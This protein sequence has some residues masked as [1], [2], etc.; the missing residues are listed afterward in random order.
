MAST[1][2]ARAARIDRASRPAAEQRPRLTVLARPEPDRSP[3]PFV[4]LCS[5]IVVAA[6]GLLLFLNIQMSDTSYRITR[7]Q[8]QSQTLT[9]KQQALQETNERLGT[10]QELERSAREIGMVPVAEPAYIDLGTGKVLGDAQTQQNADQAP[11]APAAA[12]VPRAQI[13]D[14]PTTYRGMGNEGN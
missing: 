2:A 14:Q 7:L 10:P 1:S 11:P 4:M 9:E 5:A 8:A 13:Y 3:V 6:L 12:A